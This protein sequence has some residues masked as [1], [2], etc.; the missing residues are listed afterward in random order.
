MN[1]KI[2]YAITTIL[3]AVS[4]YKDKK[5]TKMSMKKAL[6]AFENIL[7]E[8]LGVL[9]LMSVMLAFLQPETISR[10][11]GEKSGIYGVGISALIGAI[12][13]MPGFVAFPIAAILLQNGAGYAQIAAFISA[14]MMVGIVTFPLEVKYFGKKIA[15]LRNSISFI[16][17]FFVAFVIGKVM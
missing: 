11:L 17:C 10:I 7:P 3:L 4:F 9:I 12:T 8:L 5:K 14:L 16:F 13:L 15:F 2:L 6:K 1:Y